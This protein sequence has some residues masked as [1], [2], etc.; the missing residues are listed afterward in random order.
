VIEQYVFD[1]YRPDS[2]IPRA[3]Q[4]QPKTANTVLAL[5]ASKV[6]CNDIVVDYVAQN[7]GKC[8]FTG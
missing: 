5:K 7:Y 3:D 2:P 4:L 8:D 6:K 1:L